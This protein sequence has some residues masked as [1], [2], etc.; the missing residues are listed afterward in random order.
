MT[1]AISA[2]IA[3]LVDGVSSAGK[4]RFGYWKIRGMAQPIRLLLTY[5]G[6][7]W[8]EDLY[9]VQRTAEG[10]Y[11]RSQW[12]NAK[13]VNKDN[14]AFPNIPYLVDGDMAITESKA[15]LRYLARKYNIVGKT[16][17]ED[18]RSDMLVD[19]LADA[20]NAFTRLS[21]SPKDKFDAGLPEYTVNVQ[22]I[23]GQLEQFIG[24]KEFAIGS[25]IMPAD[26]ELYE[27]LDVNVLLIPAVLAQYPRLAAFHKRFEAIP[28]I[29]A[30]KASPAFIEHPINNIHA[31]FQ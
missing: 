9:E 4:I 19:T 16:L 12:T 24:D 15:I 28:S 3:S 31:S 7:D 21:Y 13:A 27:F 8:E 22:R 5:A 14:L 30:Y 6:A 17:Q 26:F 18:A 10:G 1:A 23:L 25:T 11:D 20:K 2:A 29:A